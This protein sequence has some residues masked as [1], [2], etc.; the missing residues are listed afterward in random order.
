MGNYFS[1]VSSDA[2]EDARG[3]P[4]NDLAE[5]VRDAI[6]LCRANAGEALYDR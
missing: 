5:F 3:E 2:L 4:G 6:Q 1:S